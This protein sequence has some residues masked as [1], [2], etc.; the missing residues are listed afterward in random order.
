MF[1]SIKIGLSSS[2]LSYM[3]LISSSVLLSLLSPYSYLL[4]CASISASLS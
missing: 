4:V 1:F 2:S 3:T